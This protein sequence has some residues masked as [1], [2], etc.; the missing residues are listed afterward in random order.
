MH[1]ERM[2]R[3]RQTPAPRSRVSPEAINL[4]GAIGTLIWNPIAEFVSVL[5]KITGAEVLGAIMLWGAV[6]AYRQRRKEK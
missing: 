5:P 1:A 6:K 3:Q 2:A 4:G